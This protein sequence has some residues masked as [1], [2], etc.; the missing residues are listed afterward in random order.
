MKRKKPN[1]FWNL[2]V[3]LFALGFGWIYSHNSQLVREEKGKLGF[4]VYT[5]PLSQGVN[6]FVKTF[7]LIGSLKEGGSLYVCAPNEATQL[8]ATSREVIRWEVNVGINEE[9][10]WIKKLR[11]VIHFET[12]KFPPFP[13][14]LDSIHFS[15]YLDG[16]IG[17][18]TILV[19]FLVSLF[20]YLN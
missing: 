5:M 20:Q 13:L 10:K 12:Y 11:K 15:S 4:S 18:L 9:Y 16:R 8:V 7:W 1:L 3:L 19:L 17:L 2:L 14:L 6:Y